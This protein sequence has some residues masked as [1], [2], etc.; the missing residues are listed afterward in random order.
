MYSV[1]YINGSYKL[2]EGDKKS[3]TLA[4]GHYSHEV[5]KDGWGKLYVWTSKDHT[6]N[7]QTLLSYFAAGYLEGALTYEHIYNHYWSWY[8]YTFGT[9]GASD[10]VKMFIL[11]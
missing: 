3:Y 4:W 5:D 11:D 1:D 7:E 6:T 8:D 10:N 2:R 9:E